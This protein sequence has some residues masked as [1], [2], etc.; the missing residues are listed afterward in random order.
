MEHLNAPIILEEDIKE[1]DPR[2]GRATHYQARWTINPDK[3]GNVAST[4]SSQ[5]RPRKSANRAEKAFNNDYSHYFPPPSP[6]AAYEENAPPPRAPSP[7]IKYMSSTTTSIRPKR[8]QRSKW[9]S[10]CDCKC[11]VM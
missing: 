10:I 3:D 11:T 6:P 9:F 4:S 8:H 1:V 7:V 2:S 5:L